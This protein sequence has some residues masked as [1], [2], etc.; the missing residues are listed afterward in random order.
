MA[1]LRAETDKKLL[2]HR[3][4]LQLKYDRALEDERTLQHKLQKNQLNQLQDKKEDIRNEFAQRLKEVKRQAERDLAV[5]KSQ[6]I[7]KVNLM[8]EEQQEKSK[9]AIEK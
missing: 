2:K 7:D 1:Q 3:E 8:I 6:I 9:E 4:S 5:K